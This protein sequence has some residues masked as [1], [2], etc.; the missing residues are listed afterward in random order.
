MSWKTFPKICIYAKGIDQI[1][2]IDLI[3]MQ[4]DVFSKYGWMRALKQK[5]GL[6]V[7]NALKDIF[8]ESGQK[9]ELM[10]CE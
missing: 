1:W 2:A 9:P 7:A 8:D 5:T 4:H 3:N 6:E 10:W